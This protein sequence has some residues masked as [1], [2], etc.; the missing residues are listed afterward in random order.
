MNLKDI[1]NLV[2]KCET[3]CEHECCGVYAYDFSPINIACYLMEHTVKA[4]EAEVALIKDKLN[5]LISESSQLSEAATEISIEEINQKFTPEEILI[6]A[7]EIKHNLEI[8]GLLIE[9]SEAKRF[10]NSLYAIQPN[11][12]LLKKRHPDAKPEKNS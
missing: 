12:Y 10:K 3:V 11:R 5:N 7:S 4:R 6:F 9:E 1:L 2:R 8:A